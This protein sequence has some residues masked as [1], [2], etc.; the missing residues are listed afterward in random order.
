MPFVLG[1]DAGGREL[2][3]EM[4][5]V[6]VVGV[7]VADEHRIGLGR[8]SGAAAGHVLCAGGAA[9][10]IGLDRRGRIHTGVVLAERYR[11]IGLLGR[12]GMGEVY[13]ADD[14]KLVSPSR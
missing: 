2:L 14:L 12:G 7:A 4:R 10:I 9:C 8:G 5:R 11:I 13:R 6:G 1:G 3:P